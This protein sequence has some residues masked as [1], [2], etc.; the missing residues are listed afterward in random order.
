MTEQV[1]VFAKGT[2]VVQ[3]TALGETLEAQALES[4]FEG[5]RART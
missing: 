1:A 2:R 4:F 5:L 3:A